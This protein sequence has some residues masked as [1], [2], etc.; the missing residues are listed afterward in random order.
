[1]KFELEYPTEL[2]EIPLEHYQKFMKVVSNSNDEDFISRKMVEL[3]CGVS[4][5]DAVQIALTDVMELVEHFTKLFSSKPTFKKRFFIG[6]VEY[7]FITDLENISFG[8]Y[9][10]IETNIVDFETMHKAMAVMYRPIIDKRK[11]KYQ[12]ED[13]AGSA[14]YADVMKYAPL[15]VVLPASVFFWNLGSELLNATLVSLEREMLKEKNLPIIAK[16][17]NLANGGDGIKAFIHSLKE[18]LASLTELQEKDFLSA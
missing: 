8:E 10:D 12:I 6:G 17:L 14:E 16:R 7:G 1:M 4:M 3:F 2:S 15:D 5:K 18:K 13:Y 11:D 9:L